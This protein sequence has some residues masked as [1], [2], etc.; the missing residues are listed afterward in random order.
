VIV[1]PTI[2]DLLVKTLGT[3]AQPL[4]LAADFTT[5]A[6]GIQM[7]EQ[8]A[9][10][11]SLPRLLGTLDNPGVL[12]DDEFITVFAPTNGVF[13]AASLTASSF[14]G[15]QWYGII[16]NHIVAGDYHE[17]ADYTQGATI[18]TK[19]GGMLTVLATNAPPV[20]AQGI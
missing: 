11:N 7:A 8:F 1:P 18:N 16:L 5:L 3:V 6:A 4:L 13:Q 2:G 10:T 20:P 17:T 9:A 14:N 12:I 15:Q 19:A